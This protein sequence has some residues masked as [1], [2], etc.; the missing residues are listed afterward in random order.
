MQ[1]SCKVCGA[2]NEVKDATD[3]RC[4]NCD[5]DLPIRVSQ[6]SH[7]KQWERGGGSVYGFFAA[8]YAFM[9]MLGL[10]FFLLALFDSDPATQDNAFLLFLTMIAVTHLIIIKNVQHIVGIYKGSNR[11]NFPRFI[12]LWGI[13]GL[14]GYHIA[15]ATEPEDK[16]KIFYLSMMMPSLMLFYTYY[17]GKKST[18]FN[19][20]SFFYD[21]HTPN[22]HK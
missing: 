14:F 15:T 19:R 17:F 8:A 9:F 3:I 16:N 22:G 11:Y 20:F 12:L 5:N 6:A 13:I 18:G 2:E 21:S 7:V 10:G 4:F 1:I